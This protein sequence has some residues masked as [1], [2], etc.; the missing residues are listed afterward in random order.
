MIGIA[1]DLAL[2]TIL[3]VFAGLL[4]AIWRSER[5]PRAASTT[6]PRESTDPEVIHWSPM[7]AV[8]VVFLALLVLILAPLVFFGC[9]VPALVFVTIIRRDTLTRSIQAMS[10]SEVRWVKW[11]MAAGIV[12]AAGLLTGVSSI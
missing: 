10:P 3:A 5:A 12:A 2:L 1:I 8:W 11:G 4:A 9:V 6:P 7:L